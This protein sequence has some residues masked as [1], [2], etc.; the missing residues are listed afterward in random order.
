MF[1]IAVDVGCVACAGGKVDAAPKVADISALI[2]RL[3]AKIVVLTKEG[4]PRLTDRVAFFC[5]AAMPQ[6]Q[7]FY[8]FEALF[9]VISPGNGEG[10]ELARHFPKACHGL[11]TMR[12]IVFFVP[13]GLEGLIGCLCLHGR[14]GMFKDSILT[15]LMDA[16]NAL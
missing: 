8:I 1:S 12:D 6:R 2:T 13:L 14:N 10:R 5:I 3:G 7:Y 4:E 15:G 16:D 11:L 9:T